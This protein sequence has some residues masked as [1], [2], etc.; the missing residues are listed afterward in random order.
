M[1]VGLARQK[2][3]FLE[4]LHPSTS[5]TK[6]RAFHEKNITPTVFG[7]C[8]FAAWRPKQL[9]IIELWILLSQ[10]KPWSLLEFYSG[11]MIRLCL[12]DNYYIH[13][14]ADMFAY[15]FFSLKKITI[16][17]RKM[18]LIGL[19]MCNNTFGWCNCNK[20]TK[21]YSTVEKSLIKP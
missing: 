6:I 16:F 10:F 5:G 19:S 8:F 2:L 13:I 15:V 9:S 21:K 20:Y 4:D 12:R 1:F 17:K 7:C 14:G 18:F 11:A 3:N